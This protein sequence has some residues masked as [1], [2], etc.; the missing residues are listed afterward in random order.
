MLRVDKILIGGSDKP[1]WYDR[2]GVIFDFGAAISVSGEPV[3][4]EYIREGELRAVRLVGADGRTYIVA[5][6]FARDTRTCELY[7]HTFEFDA[8]NWYDVVVE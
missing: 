8:E 4:C 6:N 2:G 7:G 1:S 3:D 5:A